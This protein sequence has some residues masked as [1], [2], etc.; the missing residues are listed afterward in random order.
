MWNDDD[1]ENEEANH[2]PRSPV[3]S[4]INIYEKPASSSVSTI[5]HTSPSHHTLSATV[6]SYV[7]EITSCTTNTDTHAITSRTV[8]DWRAD[9]LTTSLPLDDGVNPRTSACTTTHTLA[10]KVSTHRFGNDSSRQFQTYADASNHFYVSMDHSILKKPLSNTF[11]PSNKPVIS[12]PRTPIPLKEQPKPEPHSEDHPN[13]AAAPEEPPYSRPSL[14]HKSKRLAESKKRDLSD[15]VWMLSNSPA[16]NR[17]TGGEKSYLF[18]ATQD[19]YQPHAG[20][21]SFTTHTSFSGQPQISEHVAEYATGSILPPSKSFGSDDH[22]TDEN[23]PNWEIGGKHRPCQARSPQLPTP[24][25]LTNSSAGAERYNHYPRVTPARRSA[26]PHMSWIKDDE[27]LTQDPCVYEPSLHRTMK[28]QLPHP[29]NSDEASFLGTLPTPPSLHVGTIGGS[30]TTTSSFND[31]SIAESHQG[32]AVI[33]NNSWGNKEIAHRENYL[34]P[35]SFKPAAR[36]PATVLSRRTSRDPNFVLP[37]A[38]E[39]PPP[40]RS[41]DDSQWNAYGEK[42]GR[43]LRMFLSD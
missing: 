4:A 18:E 8:K 32:W 41:W 5:P 6:P 11:L 19:T 23:L 39:E 40:D 2:S 31:P 33:S 7:P 24:N 9:N 29:S 12:L 30:Y 42:K 15:E 35:E 34:T 38:D 43:P 28:R 37:P 1:S 25:S 17:K 16:S 27:N 13:W 3:T 10:S 22:W 36:H 26:I 20:T 14:S 21:G